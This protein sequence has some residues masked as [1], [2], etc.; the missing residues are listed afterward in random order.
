MKKKICIGLSMVLLFSILGNINHNDCYAEDRI[1]LKQAEQLVENV[2]KII[3][4][5]QE[6]LCEEIVD[7]I[8]ESNELEENI[9]EN[10]ENQVN[11]ESSVDEN[12]DTIIKFLEEEYDDDEIVSSI[13]E[14]LRVSDVESLEEQKF[15]NPLTGEEFAS[16]DEVND[17]LITQGYEV[18]EKDL[19]LC[20]LVED[21]KTETNFELAELIVEVNDKII[22]ECENSSWSFG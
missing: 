2:N 18:S 8:V 6:E 22:N 15:I 20:E 14:E 12:V 10:L 3:E 9:C 7:E 13:E 1:S 5:S 16:V 21:I 19:E 4:N 17:Y 11:Q